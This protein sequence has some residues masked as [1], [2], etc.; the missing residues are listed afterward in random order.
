MFLNPLKHI[1]KHPAP[2]ARNGTI[3]SK[4]AWMER[5]KSWLA[6]D[7]HVGVG[8]VLTPLF[9]IFLSER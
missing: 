5:R 8:K 9:S 3:F 1:H 4:V 2:Q 7:S 6:A